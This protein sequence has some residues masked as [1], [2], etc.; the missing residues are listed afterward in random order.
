M[1]NGSEI[2]KLFHM[3]FLRRASRLEVRARRAVAFCLSHNFKVGSSSPP[4]V[5]FL[6]IAPGLQA[7]FLRSAVSTFSEAENAKAQPSGIRK[8]AP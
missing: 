4:N 6:L 3:H 1:Y 7:D 2:Q 8:Y 5:V